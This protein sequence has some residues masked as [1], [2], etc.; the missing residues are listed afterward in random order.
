MLELVKLLL[1]DILSNH[2][3]TKYVGYV[4]LL[5]ILA[6]ESYSKFIHSQGITQCN[7]WLENFMGTEYHPIVAI[8]ISAVGTSLPGT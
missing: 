6:R 1:V 2:I 8:G 4:Y 7:M 5:K 3:R